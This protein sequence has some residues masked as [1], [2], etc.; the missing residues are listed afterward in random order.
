[1]YC[2]HNKCWPLYFSKVNQSTTINYERRTVSCSLFLIPAISTKRKNVLAQ[3]QSVATGVIP[4]VSICST[5]CKE[6]G[7]HRRKCKMSSSQYVT[8]ETTGC[9]QFK[10]LCRIHSKNEKA[11]LG[12]E[13]SCCLH[14][15]LTKVVP[16]II[17]HV[18]Q[19]GLTSSFW[20][21]VGLALGM[22]I[23]WW[24]QKWIDASYYGSIC[25]DQDQAVYAFWLT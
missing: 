16:T 24:N 1:M 15:K 4:F 8:K 21:L 13:A 19:Q 6:L 14:R 5:A 22:V 25:S 9:H 12:G 10:H 20:W 2:V 23:A 3:E 7:G 11:T 18:G 17:S